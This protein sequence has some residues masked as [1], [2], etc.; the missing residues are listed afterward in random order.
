MRAAVCREHGPPEVV[1]IEEMPAPSLQPGS[2]RV[3]IGAAAVNFPDVLLTRGMYQ[4]KPAP[5]FIPGGEAA[6]VVCAVGAGVTRLALRGLLFGHSRL[7]TARAVP[8]GS[9]ARRPRG[10]AH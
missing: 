5:P 7:D 10:A 9:N 1:R 2:V 8:G 6:G 3:R 4:F